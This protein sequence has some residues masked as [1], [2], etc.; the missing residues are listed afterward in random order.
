MVLVFYGGI[1][2][3]DESDVGGLLETDV[4]GLLETM[5]N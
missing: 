2:S 3:L 4:E 1:P 5:T